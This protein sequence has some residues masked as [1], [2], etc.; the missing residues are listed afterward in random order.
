MQV[1]EK[2]SVIH[3]IHSKGKQIIYNVIKFCDEEKNGV[4]LPLSQANA[5]AAKA[6]GKCERTITNIRKDFK[7]AEETGKKLVSPRKARKQQERISLDDF[8][9]YRRILRLVEYLLVSVTDCTLVRQYRTPPSVTMRRLN[10]LHCTNSGDIR[11]KTHSSFGPL[12]LT[13][14]CPPPP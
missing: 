2:R 3:V 1:P 11:R 8:D 14:S 9:K 6:V 4:E 5:R 13:W 10:S 12:I 7:I